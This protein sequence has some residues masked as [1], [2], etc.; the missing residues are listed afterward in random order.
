[1]AAGLDEHLET[2]RTQAR[3]A[4][5]TLRST[6][7]VLD[8]EFASGELTA[9]AADRLRKALSAALRQARTSRQL[10]AQAAELIERT[11][12]KEARSDEQHRHEARVG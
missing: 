9:E 12:P 6:A 8:S 4:A 3:F 2:F 7:D 10:A 5:R 11:Q 1:M